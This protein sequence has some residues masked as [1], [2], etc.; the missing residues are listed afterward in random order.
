MSS[1]H[2]TKKEGN[3]LGYKEDDWNLVGGR[4]PPKT[5]TR[6][7]GKRKKP[8]MSSSSSS[9]DGEWEEEEEEEE[10]EDADD[11]AK[12]SSMKMEKP[13]HQRVIVE[14]RH[15]EQ[16]FEKFARCPVCDKPL[17]L[18][19]ETVCIATGITVHCNNA[20][21]D[22]ISYDAGYCAKTK[23]HASDGYERMTDQALNVLYVLGFISMG[24]AHTEAARLLGFCGLPN[25]TTM[26]SRSFSMI[27]ERVGPSIRLLCEEI[28]R[29]I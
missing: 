1:R 4:T 16:A 12:M 22:F 14:V 20:E 8:V 23:M 2:G 3:R 19:L 26:K 29:T 18:Q 25:D 28:I 17:V 11:E 10:E 7:A 21:C 9:S 24:D 5:R 27:E 15:I 6:G 13:M